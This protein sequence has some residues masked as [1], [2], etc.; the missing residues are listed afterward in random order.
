MAG[1]VV[2]LKSVKLGSS[3]LTTDQ[4]TAVCRAIVRREGREGREGRLETL[5]LWNVNLR[6]V[7]SEVLTGAVLRLRTAELGYTRL[8]GEQVASLCRTIMEQD[9]LELE[10]LGIKGVGTRWGTVA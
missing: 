3:R 7:D 5:S 2:R 8:T 6:R 10:Y 1:A 9:G 4:V